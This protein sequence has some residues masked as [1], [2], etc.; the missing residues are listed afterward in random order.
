[1]APCM[2]RCR[3]WVQPSRP[4]TS[5]GRSSPS[6][7]RLILPDQILRIRYCPRNELPA[8]GLG[9]GLFAIPAA[10]IFQY[11]SAFFAFDVA[12]GLGLNISRFCLR[13][14]YRGYRGYKIVFIVQICSACSACSGKLRRVD[15][16]LPGVIEVVPVIAFSDITAVTNVPGLDAVGLEP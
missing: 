6:S 15:I 5:F 7:V 9:L 16:T 14:R 13:M 10:V 4:R 2:L 3:R 8:A 11:G 1:M 12:F